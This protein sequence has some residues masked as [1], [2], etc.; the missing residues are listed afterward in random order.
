MSHAQYTWSSISIQLVLW[1]CRQHNVIFILFRLY[2]VNRRIWTSRKC[3]GGSRPRCV[4]LVFF[5]HFLFDYIVFH[6][7]HIVFLFNI[8]RSCQQENVIYQKVPRVRPTI[9][10][11]KIQLRLGRS[12]D[13]SPV[14]F[15]T[16]KYKYKTQGTD[17]D[18]NKN[19]NNNLKTNKNLLRTYIQ[20][21]T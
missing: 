12:R 16:W 6:C 7:F 13:I 1:S 10:R 4:Q 21:A 14:S 11:S 3:P 2:L 17:I 18:I 9:T 19:P 5:I 20:K 8:V 15:T